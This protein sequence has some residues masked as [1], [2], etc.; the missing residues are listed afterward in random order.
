[1]FLERAAS[2]INRAAMIIHCRVPRGTRGLNPDSP[3]RR[4]P[5][6]W[7][8]PARDAWIETLPTSSRRSNHVEKS[9]IPSIWD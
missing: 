6:L 4:R 7:S 5:G 8:R 9:T 2:Q 3:F 1:V